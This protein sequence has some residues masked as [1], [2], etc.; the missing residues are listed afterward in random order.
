MQSGLAMTPGTL[1]MLHIKVSPIHLNKFRD[2]H[3]SGCTDF[4]S[5]AKEKAFSV[6]GLVVYMFGRLPAME[7]DKCSQNVLLLI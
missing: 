5:E 2:P 7:V 1:P 6:L 3:V 4:S